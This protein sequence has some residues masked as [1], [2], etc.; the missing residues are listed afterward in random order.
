[1]IK[2]KIWLEEGVITNVCPKMWPIVCIREMSVV[3]V[4]DINIPAHQ[5]HLKAKD[6]GI[7]AVVQE[8][9]ADSITVGDLDKSGSE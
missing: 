2:V 7:I 4:N 5:P 3:T 9:E 6:R 1:L 8:D